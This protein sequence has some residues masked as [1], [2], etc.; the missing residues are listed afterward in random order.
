M[1]NGSRFHSQE[2]NWN[3]VVYLYNIATKS[4]TALTSDVMNSYNPTFDPDGKYLFF[5]QDRTFT[6][7][8][9]GPSQF[10]A[11]DKTT[12]VSLI[13]LAADTKSPFLPKSD[14]EGKSDDKKDKDE[15]DKKDADKKD[16]DKKDDAKKADEKK[17][18]DAKDEKKLPE[19]K[20]DLDGIA[21]RVVNVPVA[22]DRYWG[23]F[24]VKD[25][26]LLTAGNGPGQNGARLLGL[27]LKDPAKPDLKTISGSVDGFE[28]SQDHQKVL[29][30][31]GRNYSVIAASADSIKG[32]DRV[33]LGG[34]QL[35]I[36]PRAEW[37]QMF[38]ESWRIARDFFYDPGLHGVDWAAVK[39]KYAARADG[40]GD[41]SEL[42]EILG[43][44]IAELRVGHAYI[45][46]GDTMPVARP[47]M[48]GYLGGDFEAVPGKDAYRIVHLLRG[49]GFN[50]DTRSPLLAPGLNVKEGDYILAIA[51]RPARE[52]TDIQALLVGTPG[53]IIRVTVNSKPTMEGAREILVKPLAGEG[54]ARYY[55]WVNERRDYVAKNGGENLGYIH[56]PNMSNDGLVEYTKHYYPIVQQKD[57]IVYDV[58]YNGGGYIG[59]MLLMQMGSRPVGFFKPRYGASWPREGWAFRGYR[60]AL[61]NDQDYSDAEYFSNGFQKLG[62]GPVIGVTTGGGLV[63][64]GGG[65]P[66][67]DGGKIYIPNYAAWDE[68][69][70]QVEGHG[71]RPDQVVEQ[72]FNALMA[73]K[74]PQ[75]DAAIAYL[76]K[77]IASKP[78]PKLQHPPFPVLGA[79]PPTP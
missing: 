10:F 38:Q 19:T 47:M 12:D 78:I 70:W 15:A 16:T 7:I 55:Q 75:L 56:I 77:Q 9:S 33:D 1:A 44:M 32:D 50:L 24:A 46:G 49:D 58:R 2:P 27:S 61:V 18:G 68:K 36:N 35:E 14:E 31:D 57:G 43:D 5:L 67:L 6:P 8:G 62:L 37:N 26:L 71:V 3:N 72:D 41:R 52:D 40:I 63:G 28:V 76:K 48:G 74:D 51:G 20:V 53:R 11:F 29:V 4:R 64:S 54:Q 45:G 66:L 42:N 23:I 59:G 60:V 13:T 34:I 30:K 73:G 65:Y 21:Q 39:T 17:K 69:G 79:A 22:T 25:R